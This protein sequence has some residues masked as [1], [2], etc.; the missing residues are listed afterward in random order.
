MVLKE[1]II[2]L[3]EAQKNEKQKQQKRI[4]DKLPVTFPYIFDKFR[5][6][7]RPLYRKAWN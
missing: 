2:L 1:S 5:S 4:I 6:G 7:K 3:K